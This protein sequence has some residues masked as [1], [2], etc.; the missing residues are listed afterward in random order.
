MKNQLCRHVKS[1]VH[2]CHVTYSYRCSI[3]TYSTYIQEGVINS[4]GI[5]LGEQSPGKLY[6]ENCEVLKD[7]PIEQ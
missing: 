2:K 4:S 6:R 7:E 3:G 5:R 1:M